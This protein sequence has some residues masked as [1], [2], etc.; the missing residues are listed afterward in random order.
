LIVKETKEPFLIELREPVVKEGRP[1]LEQATLGEERKWGIFY[2]KSENMIRFDRQDIGL[3]V[4]N[5]TQYDFRQ[6]QAY[7]LEHCINLQKAFGCVGENGE[8]NLES[9]LRYVP[10]LNEHMVACAVSDS[11]ACFKVEGNEMGEMLFQQLVY[12]CLS[13]IFIAA[14]GGRV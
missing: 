4:R 5:G 10:K 14:A 12:S 3:I 6:L 11:Q 8:I 9:L 7:P 1:F 13:R 2:K